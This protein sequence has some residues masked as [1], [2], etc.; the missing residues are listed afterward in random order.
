MLNR[1]ISGVM[2]LRSPTA[3]ILQHQIYSEVYFFLILPFYC[4][5]ILNL[6]KTTFEQYLLLLCFVWHFNKLNGI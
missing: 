3:K 1:V 6:K 5:S 4:Y 2:T